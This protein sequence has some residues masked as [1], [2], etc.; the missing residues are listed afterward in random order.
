MRENSLG[1]DD[2]F[3][4]SFQISISYRKFFSSWN[5]IDN[6]LPTSRFS[7]KTIDV[8]AKAPHDAMDFRADL[9]YW[10]HW[11]NSLYLGNYSGSTNIFC[12]RC[13]SSALFRNTN[14]LRPVLA[15]SIPCRPF[16]Y[17]GFNSCKQDSYS[18]FSTHPYSH[19]FSCPDIPEPR[20][21][22]W[23]TRISYWFS[24]NS[25]GCTISLGGWRYNSCNIG[26][27]RPTNRRSPL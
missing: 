2:R 16:H 11:N 1:N 25:R 19:W 8:S 13:N 6:G 21:I 9:V 10:K 15:L 5:T 12:L 4:H 23:F 20:G 24:S 3:K 27:A 14:Y 18:Y 22:K 7:W 26:P 17:L